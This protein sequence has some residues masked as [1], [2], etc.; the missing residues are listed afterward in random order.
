MFACYPVRRLDAEVLIDALNWIAGSRESY[1]SLIPEPYTFIPE[2]ERTIELEDGSITSQFL[3]MFGRPSRDTG[4]YSERNNKPSEAQRLHLLNSTSI[5]TKIDRSWRLRALLQGARGDRRR[6]VDMIYM[7]ILSRPPTPDERR[8]AEKYYQGQA[9]GVG[10]RNG[11]VD[12]TW[13]LMNT[14]EFLYRH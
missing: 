14:K 2:Q 1:S 3:E 7:T 9:K 11:M 8:A 12:L 6:L 4:L 5:Q 10:I 13:A